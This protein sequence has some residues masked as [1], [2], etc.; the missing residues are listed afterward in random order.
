MLFSS[1]KNALGLTLLLSA[2]PSAVAATLAQNI[3]SYLDRARGVVTELAQPTPSDTAIVESI[4]VMLNLAREVL[5]AYGVAHPQCATQLARVLELYP[6]IE[7]WT[8]QEIR[9]NIEVGRALPQGSGCY[10]A[11]DI[12]AHPSIVRALARSGI[13]ATPAARLTAEMNEAI[14][15]MEEIRDELV[16]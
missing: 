5:Q 6:E 12:I 16:Q 3:D 10:P 2:A 9:M 7:A 4:D 8:A 11:R 1:G 13:S 14:E 15:H